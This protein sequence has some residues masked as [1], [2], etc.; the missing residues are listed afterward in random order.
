MKYHALPQH[1]PLTHSLISGRLEAQASNLQIALN[2]SFPLFLSTLT[3][4]RWE[5]PLALP[6]KHI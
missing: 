1:L 3:V 4:P 6:A 5:R 2:F